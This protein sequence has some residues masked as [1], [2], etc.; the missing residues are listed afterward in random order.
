[1]E[2][3]WYCPFNFDQES[4][5]SVLTNKN[6]EVTFWHSDFVENLV[7]CAMLAIIRTSLLSP[8][9]LRSQHE[10]AMIVGLITFLKSVFELLTSRNCCHGH[11]REEISPEGVDRKTL[12]GHPVSPSETGH[13]GDADA[14][15]HEH[16]MF[17]HIHC[18]WHKFIWFMIS[19]TLSLQ[20]K[21]IYTLICTITSERPLC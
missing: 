3:I 4:Q 8:T 5:A 10:E 17:L 21:Y 12:R 19:F 2:I 13:K 14:S 1:M 9:L 15:L 7:V 20:C 16:S 6:R 11:N 18:S